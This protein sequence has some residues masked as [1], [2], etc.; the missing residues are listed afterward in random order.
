MILSFWHPVPSLFIASLFWQYKC[1]LKDATGP[2]LMLLT[3]H[4]QETDLEV[5]NLPHTWSNI[6]KNLSLRLF[7]STLSERQKNFTSKI[8][9]RK[10]AIIFT[11]IW[12]YLWWGSEEKCSLWRKKNQDE[13]NFS[14]SIILGVYFGHALSGFCE[15]PEPT[16]FQVANPFGSAFAAP[17]PHPRFP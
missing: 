6:E 12:R 16:F 5:W 14:F 3:L 13:F 7:R 15:P 10:R 11:W 1:S 17:H 2:L 8:P 9:E 4:I